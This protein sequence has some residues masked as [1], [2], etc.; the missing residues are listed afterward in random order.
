VLRTHTSPVLV[1]SMLSR[2]VPIYI[3]CPG[4]TF[5]TDELDATHTPV[6]HQVEGLAVDKGLTMANLRGTLDAFAR[7]LF[8]EETRTR[9]RPN[10]FPFTEPSAEVDI[11]CNFK[12]GAFRM[13]H[14][15]GADDDWM[16]I[17]GCGMVHPK[18]LENC[19]LDPAEY[20]GFAFGMGIDK[21]DVRFVAH[22]DL[23]KSI[24]S[25]YQET[26]RAGRDGEPATAWMAYGLEDAIKLKQM[27]AQSS[28]NEQHKRNENQRLESMLGLC[29][30]T[31]CR[32][33]ALLHYF[34]ETLE[35]PCGNCD[36]CLNPPQTFD[37]SEAA[38]KALSCVYRTGQRFGANHLIDVLTGNRSD[39]VASAGHDHVSTWNIGN[40]FSASQWRSIYR[41]LVARGLL[42]VDMNGFG[43]LQL[44]EA[45]RPYL[46][47]EQPL[48][49]RKE[50]A[51]AR[52]A[53]TRRAHANIADAD[54]TLWEALRACRKRL[55]DEEGVPPYVVFHD[56]TLM[57]MLAIRPRNR[58][59]MAAVSGVGDRKLERYGDAFLAILNGKDDAAGVAEPVGP[60]RNEILA[61]AQANMSP[62]AIARQQNL[63]EQ[64]VYRELAQLVT[65]H[66]LSLEQALGISETEIGI[67]QDAL[68][69]QPNLAEDTFSYRQLKDLLADDWPTGVLHCVRQA[70]L[71]TA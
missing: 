66:Q 59:E 42:T 56:A 50:M 10:Y 27:L 6:F 69:S 15:D 36:T 3:V 26:G 53:S 41:Q 48:H 55:A 34:G 33:Q 22:L 44:T 23:P 54:R 31:Q 16:E 70:I 39:K 63:N 29:E 61:L 47:G 11:G 43:A 71:A 2:D 37:A 14:Q 12:D 32:R 62:A 18:V 49:L 51:K 21:P 8:G 24:E 58:M 25:Y 65:T 7:A 19:G 64:T 13:G 4:R 1:R 46:R 38:Q 40:E 57:D 20:Q 17:L 28:G 52:K 67:I 5:R 68:L 45:C 30:I 35:Q 9:M 60:D